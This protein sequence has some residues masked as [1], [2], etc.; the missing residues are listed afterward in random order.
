MSRWFLGSVAESVIR[1]ATVPVLLVRSA[2]AKANR[3][4]AR[5]KAIVH[6]S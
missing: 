2:P 3:G 5:E 4:G 1:S 6:A